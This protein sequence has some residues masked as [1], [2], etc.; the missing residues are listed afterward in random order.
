MDGLRRQLLY[1]PQILTNP[2]ACFFQIV[3]RLQTH[4]ESFTGAKGMRLTKRR[5]GS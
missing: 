5:V 3:I 4:P 2:L 1:M